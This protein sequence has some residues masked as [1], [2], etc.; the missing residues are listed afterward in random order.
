MT[1]TNELRSGVIG[2]AWVGAA[3]LL[4]QDQ[5]YQ[6]S[7]S[8]DYGGFINV[9]IIAHEIG[10]NLNARHDGE[11]ND[12]L[13]SDMFIMSPSL[14]FDNIQN[15]QKFSSCSIDY[16]KKYIIDETG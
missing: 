14:Y 11:Q 7:L 12:C 15:I 1:Q 13:Q 6:T 3:C 9:Y 8:E 5:S 2:Y 10:H 16:F 4:T